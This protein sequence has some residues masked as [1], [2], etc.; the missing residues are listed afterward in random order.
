MGVV[1]LKNKKAS[2]MIDALSDSLKKQEHRK[3]IETLCSC[4]ANNDLVKLNE[5]KTNTKMSF[6]A[7]ARR[8]NSFDG[9]IQVVTLVGGAITIIVLIPQLLH[10][11]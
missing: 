10:L 6:V 9:V 5:I 4:K 8:T 1:K 2:E 3:F 11:F 7:R